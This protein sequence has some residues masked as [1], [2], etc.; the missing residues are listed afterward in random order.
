MLPLEVPMAL[1]IEILKEIALAT[2]A[3][4]CLLTRATKQIAFNREFAM[5]HFTTQRLGANNHSYYKETMCYQLPN[6][7]LHSINDL[8]A[9]VYD[10]KKEWFH[11]GWPH[12]D[13]D[14]PALITQDGDQYWFRYGAQ[15]RDNDQ[16]AIVESDG[17]LHWFYNG[18]PHR[19]NDQPTIIW[20]DGTKE[21]YHREKRHRKGGLPAIIRPNGIQ[22]YYLHGVEYVPE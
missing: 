13:N 15:H 19:D 11:N 16:P 2:P 7:D 1:P 10:G 22:Q 6:G 5:A 12:R 3:A 4:Y 9:V 8:P 18:W 21:W 17:S 14:R 20:Y